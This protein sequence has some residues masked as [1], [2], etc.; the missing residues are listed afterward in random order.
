[1]SLVF[2]RRAA[3]V[4]GLACLLLSVSCV[5]LWVE[6]TLLKI[7]AAFAVEQVQ[8]FDWSLETARKTDATPKN[9]VDSLEGVVQYYP[10][11]T[12]QITGSRL[13]RL[14]EHARQSAI[15]EIMAR[16]QDITGEDLGD[17]P[18]SWMQRYGSQISR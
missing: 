13:D 8:V 9:L 5:M 7:R 18:E 15:R 11:G 16:L 14:V 10:S 3:I 17:N 4:L 6:V 1:M 2:Y 12:K